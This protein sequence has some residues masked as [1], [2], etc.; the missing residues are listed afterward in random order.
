VLQLPLA[1]EALALVAVAS[2]VAATK[3][4]TAMLLAVNFFIVSP[5]S[6]RVQWR[7]E[8]CQQWQS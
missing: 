6:M 2:S 1:V 3:L 7:S 5:S 4:D 8:I